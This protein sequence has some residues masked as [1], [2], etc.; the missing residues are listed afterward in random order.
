MIIIIIMSIFSPKDTMLPMQ[1]QG[2]GLY[3]YVLTNITHFL[4]MVSNVIYTN[5]LF[6]MLFS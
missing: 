6:E 1:T 2:S 3:V 5:L 4:L